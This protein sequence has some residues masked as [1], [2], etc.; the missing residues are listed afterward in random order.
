MRVDGSG[1]AGELASLMFDDGGVRGLAAA[2]VWVALVY[3]GGKEPPEDLR[4]AGVKSLVKSLFSIPTFYRTQTDDPGMAMVQR[5][6]KQNVDSKKLGVSSFEWAQILRGFSKKGGMTVTD[7]VQL[8]NNS[9]EVNA[10]T[11]T[12]S[13]DRWERNSQ[14]I[15]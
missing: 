11:S 9:P 6:I 4:H 7:A 1:D 15:S 10:H 5:I 13:K 8:Y 3:R 12:G 14:K 2:V